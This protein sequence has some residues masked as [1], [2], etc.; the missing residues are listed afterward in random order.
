MDQFNQWVDVMGFLA[1]TAGIQVIF[2]LWFLMKILARK[3]R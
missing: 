1:I 2:C 3:A